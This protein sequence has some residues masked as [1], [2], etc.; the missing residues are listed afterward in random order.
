MNGRCLSPKLAFPFISLDALHSGS[1]SA[2]GGKVK[3]S[4]RIA[5]G[6]RPISASS[7]ETFGI[8]RIVVVVQAWVAPCLAA[9]PGMRP[10]RLAVP[11]PPGSPGTRLWLGGRSRPCEMAL[12][13]S[14]R[15]AKLRAWCELSSAVLLFLNASA[16]IVVLAFV[17]PVPSARQAVD[18]AKRYLA[19]FVGDGALDLER[20]ADTG[21]REPEARGETL[22]S[23]R[24][25]VI[26][27]DHNRGGRRTDSASR[28]RRARAGTG[29]PRR[30]QTLALR[31]TRDP[32][33]RPTGPAGTA[34]GDLRGEGSGS[35]VSAALDGGVPSRRRGSECLDGLPGMGAS[36][37][38]GVAVRKRG[39]GRPAYRLAAGLFSL[40][41]LPV[42]FC[43]AS[44]AM[45]GNL[46]WA[47]KFDVWPYLAGLVS[48]G[49]PLALACGLLR[50]MGHKIAACMAFGSSGAGD[51]GGVRL[52]GSTRPLVDRCRCRGG[53]PGSV[54]CPMDWRVMT[55]ARGGAIIRTA[56]RGGRSIGEYKA[57]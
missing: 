55:G 41:W 38:P 47:A 49:V 6:S 33:A 12:H 24:A 54:G 1:V 46:A 42:G 4:R 14:P 23:G 17:L 10:G 13:C 45:T 15:S 40:T 2:A 29:L 31:R 37:L 53:Q 9:M 3:G 18:T 32:G 22:L 11:T 34:G 26:D 5:R 57:P 52:P 16:L 56:P 43:A 19:E 20:E 8:S 39:D 35:T 21:N 50:R 36:P 28:H 30:K 44:A 7:S 48:G 27:G 25:R 51:G